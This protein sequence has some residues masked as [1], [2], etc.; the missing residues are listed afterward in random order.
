MPGFFVR[1]LTRIANGLTANDGTGDQLRSGGQKINDNYDVI[2]D[3]VNALA[4]SQNAGMIGYATKAAMVAVSPATDGVLARV[5]QDATPANNTVYRWDLS[6]SAWVVAKDY[7]IDAINAATA[8]AAAS[9]TAAAAASDAAQL[10]AGVY[11]DTATGL[12]ATTTGKYFSVPSADSNEYLILYKNN[13]GAA[14]EVKRYPSADRVTVLAAYMADTKPKTDTLDVTAYDASGYS[15]AIVDVSGNVAFGIKNDGKVE[16]GGQGDAASAIQG[17]KLAT[18][19]F[20]PRPDGSGYAFAIGDSLGNC[21]LAVLSNGTVLVAGAKVAPKNQQDTLTAEVFGAKTIVCWG[22]SLTEGTGS[23]GGQT[24]PAQLGALLGVAPINEGFGSQIAQ[25]IT[26]RQGGNAVMVTAS[27]NVIPATGA[28]AVTL[29]T[30]ILQY[31]TA[32]TLSIF[33]Y[34]G[35]IYGTLTKDTSNNYT[36]TRSASGAATVIAAATPFIVTQSTRNV[37]NIDL[38]Q[39]INIFWC[40][41]NDTGLASMDYVE[42]RLDRCIHKL[43]PNRKRFLILGPITNVAYTAGTAAAIAMRAATDSMKSHWPRNFIDIQS[44][45][46]EHYDSGVPQDVTDR[47]NGVTPSSLRYDAIHLNNTGYGIVAA[48]LKSYIDMKGWMA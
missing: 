19:H 45:L 42:A 28:V 41:S 16:V 15:Y 36:F 1:V 24:Y 6:T 10:S 22:D 20:E 18:S 40:G 31:P 13:A 3:T 48:I 23:T 11:P 7:T 32:A 5:T 47:S 38:D 21:A 39:A 14:V 25:Q 46:I 2:V 34:L 44:L 27:G 37:N 33:G 26:A 4:A 8:A 30:S 29:D 17:G 9:A 12:A 35:G 43:A